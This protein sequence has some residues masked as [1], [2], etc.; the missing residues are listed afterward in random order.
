M[1]A[2]VLAFLLG[3]AS[4]SFGAYHD[5][6]VDA[7]LDLMRGKYQ[8]RAFGHLAATPYRDLLSRKYGIGQEVVAG[9][10]V[11]REE[12][13]EARGYNEVM[14]AAIKRRFGKDIFSVTR[15]EAELT[16][17]GS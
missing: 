1:L 11:T 8:T 13:E 5:G 16:H 10:I 17:G 6:K 4:Y 15:L 2:G 7:Y 14:E 9:C 12:A 3:A